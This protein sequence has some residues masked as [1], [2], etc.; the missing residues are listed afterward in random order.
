MPNPLKIGIIGDFDAN[1]I[2]QVNTGESL[3][4]ASRELSVEVEAIWLPTASLGNQII[5]GSELDAVWAGPGEYE[6]PD[7]VILAIKDCR[8]MRIPFFAT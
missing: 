1:R 2:S 3:V 5:A 7:A 4:H 8:E 6:D